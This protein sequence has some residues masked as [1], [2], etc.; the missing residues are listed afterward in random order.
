MDTEPLPLKYWACCGSVH[1]IKF[2]GSSLELAEYTKKKKQWRHIFADLKIY[3]LWEQWLTTKNNIEIV[4]L[5]LLLLY[6]ER[7]VEN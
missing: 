1:H 3:D 2:C 6:F 5:N 7:L 4:F